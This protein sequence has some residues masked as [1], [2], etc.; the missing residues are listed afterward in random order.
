MI[1][2]KDNNTITAKPAI[3]NADVTIQSLMNNSLDD[4]NV[5]SEYKKTGNNKSRI[6]FNTNKRFQLA[7]GHVQDYGTWA[8]DGKVLNGGTIKNLFKAK[9]TALIV[10]AN[11]IIDLNNNNLKGYDVIIPKNLRGGVNGVGMVYQKFITDKATARMNDE[12][13]GGTLEANINFLQRE[14]EN[15]NNG[16]NQ[17]TKDARDYIANALTKS[18][19]TVNKLG[20]TKVDTTDEKKSTMEIKQEELSSGSTTKPNMISIDGNSYDLNNKAIVEELKKSKQ[21]LDIINS[22]APQLLNTTEADKITGSISGD[23]SVAEQ[24]ADVTNKKKITP[25]NIGDES[26][27]NYFET[28]SSIRAILPNDM[29]GAEIKRKYN[30]D[31]PINNKTIYKPNR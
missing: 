25:V 2:D 3:I 23:G 1:V 11:S 19:Y 7:K 15:D 28:L 13:I 8:A 9:T 4:L 5:Q 10:P 29:S 31:F 12:N 22:K 21:G 26:G 17:L 30:I 20:A 27:K 6:D 18:G 24:V 14:L 16:N